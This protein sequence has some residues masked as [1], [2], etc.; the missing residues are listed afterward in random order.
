VRI[1]DCKYAAFFNNFMPHANLTNSKCWII[2]GDSDKAR[3]S[4]LWVY[5]NLYKGFAKSTCTNLW[6]IKND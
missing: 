5:T 2:Y 4:D 1:L 3:L 6:K